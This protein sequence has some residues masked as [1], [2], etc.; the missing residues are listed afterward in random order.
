MIYNFKQ[1]KDI[2]CDIRSVD[3]VEVNI[4]TGDN[5]V[6]ELICSDKDKKKLEITNSENSFKVKTHTFAK[7][8]SVTINVT[9]SA[10]EN[11]KVGGSIDLAINSLHSVSKVSC[12][13]NVRAR[14]NANNTES[15]QISLA[16]STKLDIDGDYKRV[17]LSSAGSSKASFSGTYQDTQIK[18][19][20]STKV[21]TTQAVI[22]D[23]LV[24]G[25][26][27]TVYELG[28]V[29]I[30]DICMSGSGKLSYS[31]CPIITSCKTS[32]AISVKKI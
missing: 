25:S 30:L 23:C 11:I 21:D 2:V 31:G 18:T 16:G 3:V 10:V 28:A 12:A 1:L 29:E 26:G 15:V 14:I 5:E 19:S 22:K 27:S 32:G 17:E 8:D 4:C 7:V 20:G 9:A 24:C 6:L 13:G